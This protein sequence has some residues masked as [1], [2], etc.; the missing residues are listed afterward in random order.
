MFSDN[1]ISAP[2][3][4]LRNISGKRL[5]SRGFHAM[6]AHADAR[7]TEGAQGEASDPVKARFGNLGY[8][9]PIFLRRYPLWLILPPMVIVET[10][11][12]SVRKS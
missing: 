12:V 1:R 2:L 9:F 7:N 3:W 4:Y 11:K 6:G 8:M 10:S 5:R